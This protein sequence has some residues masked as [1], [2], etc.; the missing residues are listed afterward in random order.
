M[1]IK[2]KGGFVV[3]EQE[4]LQ[5]SW[6][7]GVL[8]YVVIRPVAALLDPPSALPAAITPSQNTSWNFFTTLTDSNNVELINKLHFGELLCLLIYFLVLN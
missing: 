3:Q 5:V 6:P 4:Q 7:V 1:V 2:K 8:E